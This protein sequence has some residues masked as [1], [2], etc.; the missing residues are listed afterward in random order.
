[1]AAAVAAFAWGAAVGKPKPDAGCARGQEPSSSIR[2]SAA[3][4]GRPAA[5]IDNFGG[6]P[7]EFPYEPRMDPLDS[8]CSAAWES[9]VP[10]LLE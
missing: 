8:A 9:S 7:A 3:L 10:C 4:T 5:R 6:A 1:M 2:E